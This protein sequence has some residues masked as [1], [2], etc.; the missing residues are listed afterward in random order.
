[1]SSTFPPPDG[2]QSPVDGDDSLFNPTEGSFPFKLSLDDIKK[3]A[4][5]AVFVAVSAVITYIV[6]DVIPSLQV[7]NIYVM[8]VLPL[9]AA[10][11][12]AVQKWLSDTRSVSDRIRLP[13]KQ[14][15]KI[16]AL[17]AKK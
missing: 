3:I 11:L 14:Y 4:I 17:K 5:N 12:Q 9:I 13:Y 7:D 10:G 2:D 16:Q 15:L 6:G 8:A 1:M